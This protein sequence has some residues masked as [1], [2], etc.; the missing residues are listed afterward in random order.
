MCV[1]LGIARAYGK[2]RLVLG[3]RK[4]AG[5]AAVI[6]AQIFPAPLAVG[7]LA[8]EEAGI[9]YYLAFDGGNAT[10]FDSICPTCENGIDVPSQAA[11]GAQRGVAAANNVKVTVENA[12]FVSFAGGGYFGFKAEIGTECVQ[13]HAGG[14]GFHCRCREQRQVGI[15]CHN[16][17]STPVQR[18]NRHRRVLQQWS[19]LHRTVHKPLNVVLGEH[20]RRRHQHRRNDQTEKL[21]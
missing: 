17:L 13:S 10:G 20:R 21:L 2:E 12:F 14:N 19:R 1:A 18:Q 16:R 6:G 4:T 11:V 15:V 5:G 7:H 8:F 9:T 3:E